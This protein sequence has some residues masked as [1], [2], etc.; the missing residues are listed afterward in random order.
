[1]HIITFDPFIYN[2]NQ[3]I[4][5]VVDAFGNIKTKIQIFMDSAVSYSQ[6]HKHLSS[7]YI[8]WRAIQAIPGNDQNT[9]PTNQKTAGNKLDR[10]S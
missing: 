10:T 3:V 2:L 4:L 8:V 5:Y 9:S 6:D 1:M 7:I